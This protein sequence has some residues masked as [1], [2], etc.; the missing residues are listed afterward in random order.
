VK[1]FDTGGEERVKCMTLHYYE[2]AEIVCLVYAVDSLASLS[3]LNTWVDD[4]HDYMSIHSVAPVFAL[5]GVKGDIP[6][7]DR[8]VKLEDVEKAAKH[9]DVPEDCC[10]EVSNVS[11]DGVAEMMQH[12]AQKAFDL[13]TKSTS[14]ELEEYGSIK[15]IQPENFHETTTTQGTSI[16]KRWLYCLCCCKRRVDYETIHS[17]T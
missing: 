15:A 2:N 4:A 10:F 3:S 11:G 5:V 12:L 1:V 6:L 16:C 7:G 9:F 8:E 17:S 14:V 13:H